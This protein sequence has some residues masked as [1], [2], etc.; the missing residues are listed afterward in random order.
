VAG[1]TIEV[2]GIAAHELGGQTGTLPSE[3]CEVAWAG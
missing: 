1:R 3:G 2:C